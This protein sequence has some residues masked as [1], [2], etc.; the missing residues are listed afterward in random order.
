MKNDVLIIS[1][2]VF[3]STLHLIETLSDL[4]D[5]KSIYIVTTSKV[6][7][8][9]LNYCKSIS[10]IWHIDATDND[11]FNLK[12]KSIFFNFSLDTKPILFVTTDSACLAISSDRDW[13][14]TN[15]HLSIPC[16]NIV[17]IFNNKGKAEPF[18]RN[19]GMLV[20]NTYIVENYKD[21]LL[22]SLEYPLIIK[23]S[24]RE[25]SQTVTFKTH[26]VY[27]QEELL[28]F[29]K[30]GQYFNNGLTNYVLQEYID[31][32][33]YN[34]I[35]I[36]FYR[37]K[38][39]KLISC[40]GRKTLQ[41]P[42]N[43]GVMAI[44]TV[45]FIPCVYDLC[46]HFLSQINYTG[47]GGIELKEKGGVYYFIEMSTRVEGF[48]KIE[49]L[50]KSSIIQQVFWDLSGSRLLDCNKTLKKGFGNYYSLLKVISVRL[51]QKQYFRFLFVD[52]F[53][54]ILKNNTIDFMSFQNYK[55]YYHYY[56]ERIKIKLYGKENQK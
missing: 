20:P 29:F 17:N 37:S 21:L 31:G 47:I 41:S 56:K 49:K 28:L 52:L 54:I 16:N 30:H 51:K 33:D 27:S 4:E 26:L 3:S 15:F 35:Y 24:N 40:M 43:Q 34:N 39:G 42:T 23:P 46:E 50:T 48:I 6:A 14:D 19:K 12:F 9:Y 7:Y 45:E 22:H 1:G 13:Y 36:I 25:Y 5:V 55:V 2:S 10:K 44:G 8:K 32:S 38:T 53:N 18:A 11:E